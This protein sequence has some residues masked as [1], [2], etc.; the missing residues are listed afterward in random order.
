MALTVLGVFI[1]VQARI[2]SV[3]KAMRAEIEASGGM[4]LPNGIGGNIEEIR[5]SSSD[6]EPSRIR[7]M[8]GDSGQHLI[9]FPRFTTPDDIRRAGYFPEAAVYEW[10]DSFGGRRTY[11]EVYPRKP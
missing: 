8:L 5:D 11:D 3:R 1:G 2:V 9:Y 4:F 6:L 7:R 10:A